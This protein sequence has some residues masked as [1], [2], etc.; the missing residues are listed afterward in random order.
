MSVAI[1]DTAISVEGYV[2]K[3]G[4]RLAIMVCS[5]GKL[6]RLIL[7]ANMHGVG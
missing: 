5:G 4:R 6:G 7:A 2:A 3:I 1:L